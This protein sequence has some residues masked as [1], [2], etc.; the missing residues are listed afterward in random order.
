MD[1]PECDKLL[2][3]KDKSQVI[4]EFLEWLTSDETEYYIAERCRDTDSLV[5]AHINTESLLARF[6]N[7]DLVKV[8]RE[9][10]A[11]LA[12]MRKINAPLKG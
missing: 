4:G 8:E 2:A 11:I 10:R 3:V 5:P 9:K 12:N 7:I 6:F 1:A